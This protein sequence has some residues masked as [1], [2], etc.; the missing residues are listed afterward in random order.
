MH[1]KVVGTFYPF[2]RIF[3][4]LAMKLTKEEDAQNDIENYSE[5]D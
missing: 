1:R 4:F 2:Y 5:E 3:L